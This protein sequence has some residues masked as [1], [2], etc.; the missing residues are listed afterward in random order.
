MAAC[1]AATRAIFSL[2]SVFQVGLRRRDSVTIRAGCN[3]CVYYLYTH[4]SGVYYGF[5]HVYFVLIV[6]RF[7]VIGTNAPYCYLS[8]L[9]PDFIAS[10]GGFIVSAFHEAVNG[11]I[12]A[13]PLQAGRI[14]LRTGPLQSILTTRQR[15]DTL[16]CPH[17]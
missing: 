13:L 16:L 17:P 7:Y 11:S 10:V 12:R 1:A 8:R 6:I 15:C 2:L 5:A 14:G 3:A 9:L 4:Q